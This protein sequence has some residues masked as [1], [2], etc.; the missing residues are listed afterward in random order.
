MGADSFELAVISQ[1]QDVVA[2]NANDRHHHG[3]DWRN[4]HWTKE[5]KAALRSVATRTFTCEFWPTD[6]SVIKQRGEWLYDGICVQRDTD[7]AKDAWHLQRVHL[8]AE[9]EWGIKTL[10]HLLFDFQKLLVGR[11]EHRVFIWDR[12]RKFNKTDD[13]AAAERAA[14]ASELQVLKDAVATFTGSTDGD[15]YLLGVWRAADRQFHWH[16]LIKG[17]ELVAI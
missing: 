8:I 6:S 15:R 2:R 17:Q 13:P 14:E 5:I 9:V 1:I 16:L 4:E 3:P 10:G 11:A 12:Q 7:A